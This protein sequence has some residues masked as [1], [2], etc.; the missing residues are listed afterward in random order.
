MGWFFLG[1][2]VGMFVMGMLISFWEDGK[3]RTMS[4][5]SKHH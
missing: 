4:D 3:P 2:F 1:F 5:D